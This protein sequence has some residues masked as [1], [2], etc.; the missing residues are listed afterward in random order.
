[1]IIANIKDAKRYF[2]VNPNFEKA[3]E[4]LKTLNKISARPKVK[5]AKYIPSI[6]NEINPTNKPI[7]AATT[8]DKIK[9]VKNDIPITW[10]A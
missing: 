10:K 3:F 9:A 6:L 2:G 8:T 5:I 1:M 7:P 4:F